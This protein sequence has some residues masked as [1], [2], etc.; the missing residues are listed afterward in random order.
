MRFDYRATNGPAC[1]VTG[2]RLLADGRSGDCQTAQTGSVA[3]W[4]KRCL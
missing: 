3:A 2:G 1:Q 4:R